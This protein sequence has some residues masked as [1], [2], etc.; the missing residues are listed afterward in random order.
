MVHIQKWH[1]NRKTRTNV[2]SYGSFSQKHTFSVLNVL[3]NKFCKSRVLK[4]ISLYCFKLIWHH[5]NISHSSWKKY[6]KT[7]KTRNHDMPGIVLALD[8]ISGHIYLAYYLKYPLYP[9]LN[10]HTLNNTLYTQYFC[11]KSI[12]VKIK[13][14]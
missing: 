7:Y 14:I 13:E 12:H 3:K 2:V 11:F 9:P 1:L 10:T 4:N 5:P 6:S 8:D